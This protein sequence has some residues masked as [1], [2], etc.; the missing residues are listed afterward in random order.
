MLQISTVEPG[1][2][3][4]LKQLMSLNYLK[5]FALVGGTNLSLRYGHRKSI[6]LDMFSPVDFDNDTLAENLLKSFDKIELGNLNNKIGLFCYIN[7]IKVDFVRHHFFSLLDSIEIIEGV[8]MFGINDIAAMKIFAILKRPRKKDHWDI[9][10][11]L[12]HMSLEKIIECYL[13]KYPNK[14]LLITIPKA[15]SYTG[16]VEDDEDPVS[17]NGL[18]WQKVK[19]V[20]AQHIGMYLR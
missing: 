14:P 11:L 12:N 9:A 8:R 18:T 3:D 6:D 2:L 1:T 10:E 4:L 13:K 19:K 15:L 17:L 5:D 16:D 20:I 7:E